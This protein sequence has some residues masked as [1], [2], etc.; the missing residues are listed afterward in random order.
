[1]L[2]INMFS[3]TCIR[4]VAFML[5]LHWKCNNVRSKYYMYNQHRKNVAVHSI[6]KIESSDLEPHQFFKLKKKTL[7]FAGSNTS[8]KF[9]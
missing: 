2:Q 9:G 1:M 3:F 7:E 8:K 4:K 5:L 6:I